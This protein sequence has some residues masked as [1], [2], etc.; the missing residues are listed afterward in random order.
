MGWQW[1]EL[2]MLGATPNHVV[3]DGLGFCNFFIF[4]LVFFVY[5]VLLPEGKFRNFTLE[6]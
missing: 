1:D 4:F 5:F 3:L 2:R 6:S